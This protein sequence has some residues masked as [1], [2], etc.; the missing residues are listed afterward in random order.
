MTHSMDL[1]RQRLSL[2]EPVEKASRSVMPMSETWGVLKPAA[3]ALDRLHVVAP[4]MAR[5]VVSV[6]VACE[7]GDEGLTAEVGHVAAKEHHQNLP[8]PMQVSTSAMATLFS[9][10][11]FAF[12]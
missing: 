5:V 7:L 4:E 1:N 2:L 3:E 11:F 6:M 9:S 8:L 12:P 10:N